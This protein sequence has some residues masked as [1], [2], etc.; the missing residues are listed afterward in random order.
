MAIRGRFWASSVQN[1]GISAVLRWG[2]R[3]DDVNQIALPAAQLLASRGVGTTDRYGD[4]LARDY[5]WQPTTAGG[6]S[7][8]MSGSVNYDPL[9]IR[10]RRKLDELNSTIALYVENPAGSVT[11]AY[12]FDLD[13]LLALP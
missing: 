3:L 1:A 11:A 12:A 2:I 9:N 5:F 13:L 4:W 7:A 10:S 6:T 8:Y